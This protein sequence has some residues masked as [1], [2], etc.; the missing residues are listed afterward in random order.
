MSNCTFKI[1]KSNIL[2]GHVLIPASKSHTIRALIIAALADGRSRIGR[3]LISGD[4]VSAVAMCRAFGAQIE[5]K[6]DALEVT[7]C[8]G[9]LYGCSEVID[10][11]NS[12]TSLFLGLGIAAAGT[13]E[14]I[15]DGDSQIRKRTA[16]ALTKSLNDLGAKVHD[17]I[18]GLC[19]ITISGPLQGG[20]TSIECPTSQYLSSLL[21]ACPLASGESR[22]HVP[23]LNEVPYVEMTL[24]WLS[25]QGINV[26]HSER[27]DF[28]RV[29]GGQSYIPFVGNVPAD[30]SSATFPAVLAAVSGAEITLE[31]LDMN[32]SQGD[33][34]VFAI[35]EDM[36]VRIS[37][38]DSGL[39]VAGYDLNGRDIDLNWLPDA[40][41]AL[42]VAACFAKGRTRLL[43]VAHARLKETDRIKVMCQE[44]TKM[45]ARIKELPDGLEIWGSNLH[46]A[47]LCG[48][49]DHRVV[50]ALSIAASQAQGS[51]EI[52]SAQA[53][54][55][56][57]PGFGEM[58]RGF[59]VR[60]EE[61]RS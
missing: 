17:Q 11:G 36:G 60:L 9:A 57:F 55:I 54:A 6:P 44:L 61:L 48:H 34:Q 19:P 27:K 1:E 46:G 23:L 40:L 53:V 43:N 24:D 14:Y 22:I 4:T 45:G 28:F 41:P 2:D 52:D 25:R 7:G 20:E 51:S 8:A 35:L 58:M 42:S 38:S 18:G 21:L 37:Q 15:F 12:G 33:K 32:D 47:S 3:P 26:E 13:G 31:G 10:V 5:G 29:P 39:K 50:M 59:G 16:R 56:T 49:G 30:F